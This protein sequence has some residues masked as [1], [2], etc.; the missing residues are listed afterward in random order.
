MNYTTQAQ[1][2]AAPTKD[3]IVFFNE[4]AKPAK[5]VTKFTNRESALRRCIALLPTSAPEADSE[6]KAE[7][8]TETQQGETNVSASTE[9]A[10]VENEDT[11]E[12]IN[13]RRAA[14][15]AKLIKDGGRRETDKT[16][17]LKVAK[18]LN[19]WP[20]HDNGTLKT[21]Q[22][23]RDEAAGIDPEISK[24][25]AAAAQA[26]LEAQMRADSDQ[27]TTK[28]STNV[29]P[30]TRR[31]GSG[32]NSAGV[33]A[34]WKDPVTRDKRLTRDGVLVKHEGSVMEHTS[35]RAAFKFYHLEGAKCIRFRAVL[36]ASK[37][38][39]FEQDG[40]K[41]EFSIA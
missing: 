7:E 16:A 5:P 36:K 22:E 8:S 20:Y 38:A 15:E 24:A 28:G 33:S 3:L 40:K 37:V 26:E 2:E 9:L 29:A 14:D 34:S 39:V 18:A 27:E 31:T 23:L 19:V 11:T 4:V 17:D 35:T 1:I 25:E 6:A 10:R 12:H 41:Y 21:T 13:G 30:K 32:G